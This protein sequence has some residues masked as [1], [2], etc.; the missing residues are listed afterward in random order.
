[1]AAF[2]ITK[3]SAVMQAYAVAALF[4]SGFIA[5]LSLFPPIVQTLASVLPFRWALAF[6]VELGLGRLTPDQVAT[7]FAA[8]LVWIG[9]ALVL[10]R[11]AWRAG[12]RRYSAVGA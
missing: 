10:L 8:Q 4:L 5:P 9:I 12:I 2:W 7:G 6:P 1:M 11:V 3:M